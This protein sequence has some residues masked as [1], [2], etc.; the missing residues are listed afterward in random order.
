MLTTITTETNFSLLPHIEVPIVF[1]MHA[2]PACPLL[3]GRMLNTLTRHY[4]H[5]FPHT[6]SDVLEFTFPSFFMASTSHQPWKI[7]GSVIGIP[8]NV[9]KP[10]H[11]SLSVHSAF[12]R[13]CHSC[14]STVALPHANGYSRTANNTP[15]PYNCPALSFLHHILQAIFL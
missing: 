13:G 6:Y 9:I 12:L 11:I 2:L 7:W 1:I 14:L 5:V 15:A 8:Q 4:S 10:Q 3:W